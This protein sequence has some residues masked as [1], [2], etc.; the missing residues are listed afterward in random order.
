MLN[1]KISSPWFWIFTFT[2]ILF[3]SQPNQTHYDFNPLLKLFIFQKE[4]Q[5]FL[6]QHCA[7]SS[8][9]SKIFI[10]LTKVAAY[11]NIVIMSHILVHLCCVCYTP[12][13]AMWCHGL[14]FLLI[15]FIFVIS[16]HMLLLLLFYFISNSR[17]YNINSLKISKLKFQDFSFPVGTRELSTIPK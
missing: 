11:Q 16:I 2:H 14:V 17:R 1:D 9:V 12:C 4:I 7:T 3:L 8:S 5:L 10:F 15:I 13:G 6:N